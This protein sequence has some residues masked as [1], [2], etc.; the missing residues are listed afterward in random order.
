[1]D[2]LKR[3]LP[4]CFRI[5]PQYPFANEL[6]L[7]LQQYAGSSQVVDGI[8]VSKACISFTAS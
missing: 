3:P 6:K 1:M 5:N 7:Q 4:A 8:E 2:A